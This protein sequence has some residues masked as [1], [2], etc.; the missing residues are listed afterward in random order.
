MAAD[1]AA[2]TEKGKLNTVTVTLTLTVPTT[3]V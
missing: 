2:G 3:M 1:E